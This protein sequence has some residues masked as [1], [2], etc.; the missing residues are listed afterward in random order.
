MDLFIHFE[1][2][3]WMYDENIIKVKNGHKFKFNS[4]EEE[5]L[6]IDQ[7]DEP[8]AIYYKDQNIYKSKRG[9]F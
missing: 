1:N 5:I 4:Q 8:I 2:G 3:V 7:N 6:I 9:L